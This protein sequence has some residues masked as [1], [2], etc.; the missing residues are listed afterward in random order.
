MEDITAFLNM[1]GYAPFVWPSLGIATVILAGMAIVSI[2]GLRQSEAALRAAE[3]ASPARRR[4]S[5]AGAGS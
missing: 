3:A 1:G 5:E 2:R 4:R